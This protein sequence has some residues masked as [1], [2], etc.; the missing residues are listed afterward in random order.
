MK[1]G[2][3]MF[4]IK[5]GKLEKNNYRFSLPEGLYMAEDPY[6]QLEDGI[7]FTNGDK[8]YFTLEFSPI[9]D[10]L[11]KDLQFL[12]SNGDYFNASEVSK[13]DIN[14]ITAYSMFYENKKNNIYEIHMAYLDI[15][16]P[17]KIV[18]CMENPKNSATSLDEILKSKTM[19]DF[20]NSFEWIRN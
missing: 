9:K 11:K 8:L 19:T 15:D 6:V 4:L 3:N 12:Y 5:N 2:F 7:Y 17:K 18:M 10:S 20:I 16:N 14:G 13:Q 1:E